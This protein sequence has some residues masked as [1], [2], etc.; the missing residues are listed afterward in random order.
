MINKIVQIN[1][2][3]KPKISYCLKFNYLN[4]AVANHIVMLFIQ[5][6]Q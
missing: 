3:S 4:T 5:W 6:K 1:D 2:P